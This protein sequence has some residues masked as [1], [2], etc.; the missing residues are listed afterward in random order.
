[1]DSA[2][3]A[4]LTKA[5]EGHVREARRTYP[6]AR[7]RF[8]KG[9]PKSHAFF[10]T[11]RIQ[12]QAGRFEQAFV[13]VDSLRGTRVFGHIASGMSL[14]GFRNGQLYELEEADVLDWTVSKPDGTEDGNFIG[15]YIDSLQA[16]LEKGGIPKP[17]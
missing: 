16:R 12:G 6:G 17:C 4:C 5:V 2:T 8:E 13:G 10:V 1:M 9:L 11:T 15:K 7:A 3:A 14:P